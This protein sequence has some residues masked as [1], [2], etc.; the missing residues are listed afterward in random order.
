ML[1]RNIIGSR[2][3]YRGTGYA[4]LLPF[5]APYYMFFSIAGALTQGDTLKLNDYE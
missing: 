5:V 1:S 4:G 2:P 3:A